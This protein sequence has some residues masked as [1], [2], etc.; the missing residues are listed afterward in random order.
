[1]HLIP[2]NLI[3]SAGEKCAEEFKVLRVNAPGDHFGLGGEA[4]GH[5]ERT[6]FDRQHEG[7]GLTFDLNARVYVVLNE[8]VVKFGI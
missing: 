1:M 2:H 8:V 6:A 3:N 5:L 7:N 4:G